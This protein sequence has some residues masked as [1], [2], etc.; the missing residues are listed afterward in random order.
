MKITIVRTGGF[1]GQTEQLVD[2]DTR[3]LSSDSAVEAAALISQM[4]LSELANSLK[5]SVGADL[6]NYQITVC[7]GKRQYQVNIRDGSAALT[8]LIARLRSLS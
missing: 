4:Q 5:N 3:K 1:A 8:D 2:I 7:D 6:Y